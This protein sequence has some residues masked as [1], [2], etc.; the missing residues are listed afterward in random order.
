MSGPTKVFM[1]KQNMSCLASID[2]LKVLNLKDI[3][4][5]PHIPSNNRNTV[6]EK[7]ERI[8]MLFIGYGTAYFPIDWIVSL[9]VTHI[10][11][12]KFSV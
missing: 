6:V 10:V 4:G 11:I 8:P 3:T 12:E 7:W 9:E 2:D 5:A 1:L